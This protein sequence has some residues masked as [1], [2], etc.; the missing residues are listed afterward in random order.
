M[1][2]ENKDKEFENLIK[3]FREKYK[4]YTPWPTNIFDRLISEDYTSQIEKE[5][6]KKETDRNLF[7]FLLNA[8]V[9]SKINLE[10]IKKIF[11]DNF[12]DINK[13]RSV[14]GI[15]W[16]IKRGDFGDL[17]LKTLDKY[18]EKF[19]ESNIEFTK[20]EG[21]I[22]FL[23]MVILSLGDYNQTKSIP[24]LREIVETQ[25]INEPSLARAAEKALKKLEKPK[26]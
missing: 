16:H 20:I 6:L 12:N 17:L 13:L 14:V 19:L 9:K 18:Y 2:Q 10:I 1:K 22:S 8:Y 23:S 3:E 26:K 11:Q 24:K 4:E 21:G 15:V 25:K 5:L 7:K